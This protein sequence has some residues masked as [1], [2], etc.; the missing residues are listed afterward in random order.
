MSDQTSESQDG[1]ARASADVEAS[2]PEDSDSSGEGT[3][4]EAAPVEDAPAASTAKDPARVATV[5]VLALCV[6]FFGFY[7][8]ADR[9]MP[10]SDQARVSGFTVSVVP[11]VSG[12]VTDIEVALHAPVAPGDVLLQI[13]TTQYEIAVRAARAALDNAIQQLGVQSAAIE[14]GAAGGAPAGGHGSLARRA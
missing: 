14:S 12:V 5:V 10:Y 8:W 13:D 9:V 11:L 7:L 6:V 3:P 2:V 4:Q 1:E